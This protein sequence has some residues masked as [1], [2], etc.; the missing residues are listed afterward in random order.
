MK[1]MMALGAAMVTVLAMSGCSSLQ[2]AT[3]NDFNGQKTV[4]VG[5]SVGHVSATNC[6]LY[7]LWIPLITGSS[8]NIGSPAFLQDMVN[9][10]SLAGMV[11]KNAGF[12]GSR[13]D[14]PERQ[15]R[16]HLLLA[17][18]LCVGQRGEVIEFD[19]T[20]IRMIESCTK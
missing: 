8:E 18:L 19:Q 1:K 15:R 6:G 13:P 20:N 12:Q 16:L 5:T 2:T 17:H 7:L 9:T 3:P 10:R 14:Y 11:T 4:P